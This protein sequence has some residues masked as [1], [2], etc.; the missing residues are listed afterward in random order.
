MFEKSIAYMITMS[1]NPKVIIELIMNT[2]GRPRHKKASSP[3][4][5]P[6]YKHSS[7]LTGNLSYPWLWGR[8]WRHQTSWLSSQ[9]VTWALQQDLP[10]ASRMAGKQCPPLWL[11][12]SMKVRL[13]SLWAFWRSWSHSNLVNCVA[14]DT[15]R[16]NESLSGSEKAQKKRIYWARAPSS[17][18]TYLIIVI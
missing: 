8:A 7:I 16:R 11:S 15:L 17:I 13:C 1:V 5:L 2:D 12:R 10:N 18:L 6:I 3:K 14:E 4:D 9:C